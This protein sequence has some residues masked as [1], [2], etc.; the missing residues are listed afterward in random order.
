[1]KK[2]QWWMRIVG[3]FYLL[4][5]LMNLIFLFGT[6][7]SFGENLPS[8]LSTDP[9]AVRAFTDAWMVFV[10]EL[11][12]LGAMLLYGSGNPVGN[13]IIVWTVIFAEVFRG[14]V[15]DGIWITRGYAASS[16][17][18]FMVI[19][20]LIIVTGWLFLRQAGKLAN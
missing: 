4:L 9:L 12:V 8:P 16:Y 5:T 20:L 17:L 14:I 6:P 13:K 18:P 10:F 2:L 15:A 19:H 11:G 1:M 7:E 3:G